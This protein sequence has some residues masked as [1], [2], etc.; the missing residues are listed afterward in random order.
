[1]SNKIKKI[2][3]FLLICP[4]MFVC[5]YAFAELFSAYPV[6]A[7]CVTSFILCMLGVAILPGVS[8]E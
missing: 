6:H 7:L 8:H 4:F 2:V 3:G 5:G 1:M